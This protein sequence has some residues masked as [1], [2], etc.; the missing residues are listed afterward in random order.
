MS[1]VRDESGGSISN[2]KTLAFFRANETA[3]AS[4]MIFEGDLQ[5]DIP[6]TQKQLYGMIQDAITLLGKEID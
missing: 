1:G 4:L 5:M 3:C 2:R 6:L